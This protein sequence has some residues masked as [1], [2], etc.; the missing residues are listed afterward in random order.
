MT[1]FKEVNGERVQL[2]PV[3]EA[4]V[5]AERSTNKLADAKIKLRQQFKDEALARIAAEVPAWNSFERIE[6]LLSISNLLDTASMTAAQT[7]AKD[8]LIY[9]RDTAI[10]HVNWLTL[11]QLQLV[12]PTA[13]APFA[14]VDG[15]AGWPT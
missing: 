2:S 15:T 7:L 11:A 4:A 9:A 14:A 5:L 10:P 12:D 6:F 8:T 1:L 13:A 3:E